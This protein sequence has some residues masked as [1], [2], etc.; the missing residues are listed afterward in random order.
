MRFPWKLA[1][2]L[3]C[4]LA[5]PA[6]RAHAQ[7][8]WYGINQGAPW[9]GGYVSSYRP[10]APTAYMYQ[11]SYYSPSYYGGAPAYPPPYVPSYYAG[12]AYAQPDFSSSAGSFYTPGSYPMYSRPS[13][14]Y[15]RN[16]YVPWWN[17]NAYFYRP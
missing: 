17:T 4:A 12:R 11:R 15:G 2:L 5:W 7:V 10:A 9:G 1:I 16:Y 14:Y 3:L 13:Y 6:P 8:S